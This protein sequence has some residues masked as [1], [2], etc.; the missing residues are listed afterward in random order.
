MTKEN[1]HDV[2]KICA[3]LSRVVDGLQPCTGAN[4]VQCYKLQYQIIMLFG[5]TEFKAQYA[6]QENVSI[7]FPSSCSVAHY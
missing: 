4:G 5:L 2:F 6:W 3:D 1:F 7:S